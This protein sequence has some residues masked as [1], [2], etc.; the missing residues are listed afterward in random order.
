MFGI[1][2]KNLDLHDYHARHLS[3]LG[4]DTAAPLPVDQH[5]DRRRGLRYRARK[6]LFFGFLEAVSGCFAPLFFIGLQ[7]VELFLIGQSMVAVVML[8]VVRAV[9]VIGLIYAGTFSARKYRMSRTTWRGIRFQQ[10]GS[11][12]RY[13][14]IALL[15]MLLT[16]LTLG[17]YLP[18]LE[19]KLMR[20]ETE[21][22]RFA[23]RILP[24]MARPRRSS[25]S[26]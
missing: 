15:G 8:N 3:L 7:L 2:Y 26:S 6:E 16:P 25:N 4:E 20:Y 14:G 12:W 5:A 22:L 9:L 13:A 23:R 18:Y 10:T 11:M 24:S 19:T 17:L 21:N 1:F